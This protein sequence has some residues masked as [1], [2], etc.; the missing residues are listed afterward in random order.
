[1]TS[2]TVFE[3]IYQTNFWKNGD[4]SGTGSTLEYTAELRQQLYDIL[5]RYN[6]NSVFD[7]GCGACM[8]TE[9]L[10]QRAADG[11]PN[12][13]YVGWDVSETAIA[14]ARSR[15]QDYP[16]ASFQVRDLTSFPIPEGFDMILS[17]DSLQHLSMADCVKVLQNFAQAKAKIVVVGSY[18]PG[19]NRDI[20]TGDCY[21]INLMKSPFGLW[22][23]EIISEHV[24]LEHPQK[25]LLVFDSFSTLPPLLHF[26]R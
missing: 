4:G 10:L 26:G 16:W 24:P 7:A 14:R 8:W 22:P 6:V 25:H 23:K 18:L 5:Q 19:Y 3:H 15:M 12:F 2:K 9:S 21:D 1:M 20:Q 17:R 13:R 11:I